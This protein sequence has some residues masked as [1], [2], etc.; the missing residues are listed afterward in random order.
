M[1]K[2]ETNHFE[3][4]HTVALDPKEVQF[5]SVWEEDRF[6]D[7]D[8]IA[9]KNNI[10]QCGQ[11]V[12]ILVKKTAGGETEVVKGEA[13][14]HAV[15]QLELPE[16]MCSYLESGSENLARYIA[17]TLRKTQTAMQKAEAV[18]SIIQSDGISQKKLAEIIG[19]KEPTVSDMMQLNKLPESIK[20]QVRYDKRFSRAM[21]LRLFKITDPVAQKKDFDD[22]IKVLNAKEKPKKADKQSQYFTTPEFPIKKFTGTVEWMGK[23][24]DNPTVSL[25]DKLTVYSSL[26]ANSEAF[27]DILEQYKADLDIAVPDSDEAA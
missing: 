13:R 23:Y 2:L 20:S 24:F 8:F 22:L 15:Q 17:T 14:L 19:K 12:P 27:L 25:N 9:L 26:K 10:E 3:V 21:L 7:E 1:D 6:A 4:S 5:H 18:Q 11:L 16:I